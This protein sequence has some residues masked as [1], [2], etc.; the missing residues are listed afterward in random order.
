MKTYDVMVTR[1][2]KW[3]MIEVPTIDGLTQ[4]RRLSEITDMAVSLIA[5]TVDVAA[6]QVGVNVVA[7]IVDGTDLVKRRRQIDAEREAA[8]E[9][10]GKAA[11]LTLDLV[12]ELDAGHVPLRD[13][14]EVVGVSFQRVHQLLNAKSGV[15]R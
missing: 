3:W 5:V 14:G 7:M 2:G 15:A 6:S 8:R 1:Q 11:T 12:R 4:A 9:A 13:I 10:E